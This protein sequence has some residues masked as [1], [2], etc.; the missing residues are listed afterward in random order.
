VTTFLSLVLRFLRFKITIFQ[1]KQQGVEALEVLLPKTPVPLDPGLKLL[2]RCGTQCVDSALS[3][4]AN[5]NQPGITEHSQMFGNLR[6]AQVQPSDHVADRA[7]AVPQQFDDLE[8]VRLSQRSQ[9]FNNGLPEYASYRIFLS[10]NIRK[11]EY[12]R[13]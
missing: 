1:I 7:W 13:I 12:T 10:R 3:V 5:V 2:K 6:L 11:K 4:Y 8:A 9:S